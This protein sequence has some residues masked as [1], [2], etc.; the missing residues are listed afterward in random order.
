MQRIQYIEQIRRL[1]YGGQP[2]DDA[3]ITIGLVNVWLDQALAFAAK[4]NYKDSIAIDGIAYI[5]N[6]FYTTFKSLSISEDEQFLWKV[7]LPS[8]PIGIGT[9]EGISTL[10]IKDNE[11]RQ[12]SQPIVWLSQNQR[13]FAN[14]MRVIPNKILGYVEG[15][16]VYLKST[17]ILSDYTA[18]ATMISGGSSSD[19]YGTMNIPADYI[20]VMTQYLRE[21]LMFERMVPRDVTPDGNDAVKF[22]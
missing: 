9:S 1:I 7:T 10:V 20:P 14:G 11:S 6:S 16:F 17:L 4:A 18:Q 19:L 21:Q 3:E 8:I 15:T 2:D 13:S 22:T 5:N 12:L